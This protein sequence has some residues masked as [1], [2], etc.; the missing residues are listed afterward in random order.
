MPLIFADPADYER[1]QKDDRLSFVALDRI[2][3]G[4][5]VNVQLK[6]ADGRVDNIEARHSLTS[7]QIAWFMAGSA[8]NLIR[9]QFQNKMA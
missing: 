9:S 6:H 1:I 4:K 2:A 8:I 5:P 7:E 3:P